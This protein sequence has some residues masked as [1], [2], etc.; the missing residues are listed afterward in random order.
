MRK[1]TRLNRSRRRHTPSAR[2]YRQC[3]HH[4]SV[5]PFPVRP[6]MVVR[7][8][9]ATATWRVTSGLFDWNKPADAPLTAAQLGAMV[10]KAKADPSRGAL[11]AAVLTQAYR[12]AKAANG[13][14]TPTRTQVQ[15]QINT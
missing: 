13:G 7:K 1:S 12:S 4:I 11:G 9:D 6:S 5:S 10:K 8:A 3:P 14:K 15:V 2:M